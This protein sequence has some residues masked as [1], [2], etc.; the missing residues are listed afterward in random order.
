MYESA[1]IHAALR[2]ELTMNTAVKLIGVHRDSTKQQMCIAWVPS[3]I[4]SSTT[5]LG[6]YRYFLV[7]VPP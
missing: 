6:I 2:K 4:E 1:H 7:D 5:T 3:Q